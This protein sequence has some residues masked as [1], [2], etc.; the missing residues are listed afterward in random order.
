MSDKETAAKTRAQFLRDAFEGIKGRQSKSDDELNLWLATDEGKA[1]V[2][3]TQNGIEWT[4]CPVSSC[5]STVA[6]PGL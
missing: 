4:M 5:M 3:T 2:A 1:L 6:S